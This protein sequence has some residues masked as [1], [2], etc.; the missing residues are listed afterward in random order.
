M[1]GRRTSRVC[2]EVKNMEYEKAIDFI[3]D[4]QTTWGQQ[5]AGQ[6]HIECAD[7]VAWFAERYEDI[8]ALACWSS[9]DGN[10]KHYPHLKEHCP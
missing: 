5:F 3:A 6:E 2:L 9:H 1:L 8:N 7:F 4:I 10:V